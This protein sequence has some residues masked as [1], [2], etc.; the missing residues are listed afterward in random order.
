MD[1]EGQYSNSFRWKQNP[2]SSLDCGQ[3]SV[4]DGQGKPHWLVRPLEGHSKT[5]LLDLVLFACSMGTA[6]EATM[7]G[8]WVTLLCLSSSDCSCL[9]GCAWAPRFTRIIRFP[10]ESNFKHV[11][12]FH[13]VQLNSMVFL[14]L[15]GAFY[16][17]AEFRLEVRT[18]VNTQTNMYVCIY[19]DI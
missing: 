9:A 13:H 5:T 1:D 16:C 14:Q 8:L 3:S 6:W 10:S 19:T 18:D 17:L 15:K 12:N 7:E 11:L 2:T 4:G